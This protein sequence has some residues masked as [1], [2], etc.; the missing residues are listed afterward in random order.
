MGSI[1][2]P[3]KGRAAAGRFVS[4]PVDAAAARSNLWLHSR[5]HGPEATGAG[6]SGAPA[7]LTIPFVRIRGTDW[8]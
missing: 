8:A 7:A 3:E 6:G 5:D 1:W 2:H 4:I